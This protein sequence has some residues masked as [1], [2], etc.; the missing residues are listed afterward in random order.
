MT[1]VVPCHERDAYLLR[2]DYLAELGDGLVMAGAALA[3]GACAENVGV[4]ELALRTARA[5]LVDAIGEFK[6]LPPQ[7][8]D[9]L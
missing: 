3:A 9:A 1:P 4:I 5:V 2:L 8:G 6:S 7:D